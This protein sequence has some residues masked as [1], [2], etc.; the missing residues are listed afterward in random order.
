M[1]MIWGGVGEW[2]VLF[3]SSLFFF[4]IHF[5]VFSGKIM[6]KCKDMNFCLDPAVL[7]NC[8]SFSVG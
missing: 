3:L 5:S 7:G 4:Y 8:M 6:L 1:H 2:E